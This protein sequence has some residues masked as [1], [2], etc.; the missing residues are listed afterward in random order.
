VPQASFAETR[1]VIFNAQVQSTCTLQVISDGIMT[2]SS[3]LKT[4]TSKNGDASAGIVDLSTTGG[5]DVSV[6][7]A[8]TATVPSGD[9]ATNWLPEYSLAGANPV[10]LTSATSTL[11]NPGTSTMS[12]H[13]TGTK[14]GTDRFMQ[15]TYQ[16]TV[17]VTCE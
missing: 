3:D 2:I 4:L 1:N 16:A 13:L 12:V 15:G 6:N 8:V 7:P 11:A 17:V 14:S 5:V 9:A 10:T